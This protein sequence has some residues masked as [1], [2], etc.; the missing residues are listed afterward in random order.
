MKK[1][2]IALALGAALLLGGA[3]AAELWGRRRPAGAGEENRAV[4][5]EA[6]LIS[7]FWR[8]SHPNAAESF[9]LSFGAAQEMDG[10]PGCFLNGSLWSPEGEFLE[11]N[12]A[13]VSREQWQRLETELRSLSLPPYSPPDPNVLDAADNCVEINWE[14]NGVRFQIRGSGQSAAALRAFV[15]EL[16]QEI[17]HS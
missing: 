17:P 4:S 11:W 9:V 16:A 15:A 10:A 14:E 8:Q 3:L 7:F 13:P 6:R 5:A 1:T 12:D 2:M